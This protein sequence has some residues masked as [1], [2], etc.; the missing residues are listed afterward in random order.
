MALALAALS[1][2]ALPGPSSLPSDVPSFLLAAAKEEKSQHACGAC[3]G[4]GG[5]LCLQE[6][7]SGSTCGQDKLTKLLESF[8]ISVSIA[9]CKT[10]DEVQ[11]CVVTGDFNAGNMKIVCKPP[12][13]PVSSMFGGGGGGGAATAKLVM[14]YVMYGLL[15]GLITLTQADIDATSKAEPDPPEAM[16]PDDIARMEAECTIMWQPPLWWDQQPMWMSRPPPWLNDVEVRDDSALLQLG[17]GAEPP[18]GGACGARADAARAQGAA[19]APRPLAPPRAQAA[20]A[21]RPAAVGLVS[22]SCTE[23]DY[24]KP[25]GPPIAC[26]TCGYVVE[27]PKRSGTPGGYDGCSVFCGRR[28][29]GSTSASAAAVERAVTCASQCG[30]K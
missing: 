12:D 1:P 20:E 6:L 19:A 21:D 30:P 29:S 24:R 27:K 7:C 2:S 10:A 26:A 25:A 5:P 15:N 22:F 16:A 28:P 3:G 14:A 23:F 9:T 17:E 8:G 11:T 18:A 13:P 4:Y